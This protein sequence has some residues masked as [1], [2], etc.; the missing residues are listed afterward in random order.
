MVESNIGLLRQN[1]NSPQATR[2]DEDL[3][4]VAHFST[5]WLLSPPDILWFF[6]VL[7]TSNILLAIRFSPKLIMNLSELCYLHFSLAII[8]CKGSQNLIRM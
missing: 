6:S 1:K 4:S 8:G 7:M 3:L 2:C 5:V